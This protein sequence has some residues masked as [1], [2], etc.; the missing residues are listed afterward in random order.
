[1][2]FKNVGNT[3]LHLPIRFSGTKLEVIPVTTY[4]DYTIFP[5]TFDPP[6]SNIDLSYDS[7]VIK[8]L[9]LGPGETETAKM[10]FL[11][12][13]KTAPYDSICDYQLYYRLD[14]EDSSRAVTKYDCT[15]ENFLT[16]TFKE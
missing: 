6:F 4:Q 1:M 8:E 12:L 7:S 11:Y 10:E 16:I 5:D 13:W 14:Y 9:I 2:E 3:S 15:S